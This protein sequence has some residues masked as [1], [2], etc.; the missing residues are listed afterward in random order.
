MK[1][2]MY[3]IKALIYETTDGVYLEVIVLFFFALGFLV[4]RTDA[5]N[6]SRA[7]LGKSKR[8]SRRASAEFDLE[9]RKTMELEAAVGHSCAVLR[10]W[11][12]GQALAPTP[13]D[14]VTILAKAF[15]DAEPDALCVEIVDHI[16][17][18]S[19]DI[20]NSFVAMTLLDTVARSGDAGILL[21]LWDSLMQRAGVRRTGRMYEVLL[22]GLAS[23]GQVQKVREFEGQMRREKLKL[24]AR[25]YSLIVKG[26]LKNGL[27]DEVLD[28]LSEMQHRGF[29][30]PS[31]A[32]MQ[33]FRIAA[34]ADRSSEMVQAA[35]ERGLQ[36][37][38][39]AYLVLLEDCIKREDSELAKSLE[40]RARDARLLTNSLS[41]TLLKTY[42][43]LRSERAFVLLQE[44]D[45]RGQAPSESVCV[46]LLARCVKSQFSRFAEEIVKS[47]RA[48]SII[49]IPVYSALMKVYAQA[50]LYDKACDLY[51]QVG[52][53]GLKPDP[54]MYGCLMKFALECGRSELL[55]ELS[56]A[57]PNLD[58]QHYM[59]LIKSAGQDH[60]VD[61]AFEV[62]QQLKTSG[63]HLDSAAL[64]GIL[65][66]CAKAGD[67]RRVQEVFQEL[68]KQELADIITYNT[69][70]KALC[71]NGDLKAAEA[72]LSEIEDAGLCPNDV[73]YNSLLNALVGCGKVGKAWELISRME[74][75]GVAP[76][77][78]TISIILKSLKKVSAPKDVERCFELLDRYTIDIC[79]DE[80]LLTAVL[81]T[82]L[83]HKLVR[84]LG[85]VVAAY[86]RSK[87]QPSVPTCGVIIK[88]YGILKQP[89]KCW[90]LWKE[91]VEAR[92]REPTHIVHGCMLDA[93]VCN[94]RIDEAVGL[95]ES[96]Q[97]SA[98]NVVLC[99]ILLKG[100]ASSHQPHRAE[101]LWR[102]MRSKGLKLNLVAYNS[103]IDAQ[104]RV[105]NTNIIYEVLRDMAAEAVMPDS[106]THS[107]V[108]KAHCVKGELDK[109]LES[110]RTV[111]RNGLRHDAVVYNTML[112]ASS[113]Q[114][115]HDLFEDLLLDMRKHKISPTNFTLAI[116]VRNYGRQKQL[117]RAFAAM[118]QLPLEGA[119]L[120]NQQVYSSLVSTCATNDAPMEAMKYFREMVEAGQELDMHRCEELLR[121]LM[122]HDGLHDAVEVVN[123][124][125]GLSGCKS[126]RD[127]ENISVDCLESLLAK[128]SQQGF[129]DELALPLLERLRAQK[130]SFSKRLM[131]TVL[132]AS[133]K[134][135]GKRR[136]WA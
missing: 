102:D 121:C 5:L 136:H 83:R 39:D 26:F 36:M 94:D 13:K 46:A 20:R 53:D 90:K 56:S 33:F 111:Q 55:H 12:A 43:T 16:R 95:F 4:L 87:L 103:I 130:P 100:F 124:V 24:T 113:K 86:E 8:A 23:A 34:A 51:I 116:A 84:R 118:Q 129:T 72:T 45:C 74:R 32:V 44:M 11:R 80:I 99:S 3:Q 40:Q 49:S 21:N 114:R 108:C 60:D 7:K 134:A 65:D 96:S 112:D 120:P 17:L 14:L 77:Q 110:L 10:A 22:A 82:C 63:L 115:R 92:S 128:I 52:Q 93:L 117:D 71:S 104:A 19:Q 125:F 132:S 88:A 123:A 58:I 35:S 119:F 91:L 54:L 107:V 89:D 29:E 105:G 64:N 135:A 68:K 6:S 127:A 59:T 126:Y 15:L 27:V 76:D 101:Q 37:C 30:V 70:I 75:S 9:L 131:T 109:A 42:A 31:F 1:L 98:A 48:R 2:H 81:E 28:K 62:L 97:S 69:L 25:G 38:Q 73:S 133:P 41:E 85:T 122:S 61:R 67:M 79:S 66:V 47:C 57:S 106:I 50:G 18:H 78:Y